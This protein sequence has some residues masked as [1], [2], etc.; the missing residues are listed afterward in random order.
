[1]TEVCR[2][3]GRWCDGTTQLGCSGREYVREQHRR[4]VDGDEGR[5]LLPL[6]LHQPDPIDRVESVKD[7]VKARMK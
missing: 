3:S 7:P 1:M 6:L 5:R 4:G 2:W